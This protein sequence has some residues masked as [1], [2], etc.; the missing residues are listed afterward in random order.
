M[1]HKVGAGS[2]NC[3][4]LR[5]HYYHLPPGAVCAVAANGVAPGLVSIARHPV[6]TFYGIEGRLVYL[7]AGI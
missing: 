7:L 4:F 2:Y 6:I 3:V 1:V 5:K